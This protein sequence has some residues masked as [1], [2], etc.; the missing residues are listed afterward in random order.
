MTLFIK[1]DSPELRELYEQQIRTCRR[2]DAGFDLFTSKDIVVP[3][4]GTAIIT[5][6]IS[7][8]VG[9]PPD[10]EAYCLYPRSS[11]SKTPLMMTN[12][13]GIIDK[14]YR[15]LIMAPVRNFSTSDYLVERGTRLFQLTRGDLKCF[16]DFVL[17]S[18]LPE[19]ERGTDG[20]GS[21]GK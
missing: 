19:S 17:T 18:S 13:V 6:E 8:C 12:S 11:I 9:K 16:D 10:Y 5:F 4:G 1:V 2:E 7:C 15:G 14:G 3:A 20:F 21:T